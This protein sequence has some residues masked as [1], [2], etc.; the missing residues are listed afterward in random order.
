MR[1]GP[2]EILASTF[3][4]FILKCKTIFSNKVGRH[5]NEVGAFISRASLSGCAVLGGLPGTYLGICLPS[6]ALDHSQASEGQLAQ[7]RSLLACQ[8]Q[9]TAS[10]VTFALKLRPCGKSP[11]MHL[12]CTCRRCCSAA[13]VSTGCWINFC[14]KTRIQHL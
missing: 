2:F 4:N 11:R 12:S 5:R 3:L 10:Y 8:N 14:S 7:V 1:S 6:W 9:S 13:S